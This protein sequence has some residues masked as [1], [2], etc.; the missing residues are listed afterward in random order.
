MYVI[1]FY[2]QGDRW[3][4]R[5]F[6]YDDPDYRNRQQPFLDKVGNVTASLPAKYINNLYKGVKRFATRP[7][8]FV[9]FTNEKLKVLSGIEVRPFKV[10][11]QMGVLPRLYMFSKEAGLFEHQVLCLDIDVVIVGSLKRIMNYKGLFC[12]RSK[13]K[14]GEGHK[15]DGD[16]MSFRAGEETE[17]IF[18]K[19]FIEDVEAAERLTGGRERYWFRHLVNDSADRWERYA[20]DQVIS[21][22]RHVAMQR[23]KFTEGM[24]VSIKRDI[25]NERVRVMAL[26]RRSNSP[27][28][29][30]ARIVSCHGT[31]RP[32]QIQKP[33]IK[34]YW[35]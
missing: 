8:E 12:A 17:D 24:P 23:K 5:G 1:C 33:W 15:L 26:K 20:P 2:W 10:V 18:W 30:N 7:F 25:V 29:T 35:K 32:D 9:C 22:K 34:E 13:F 28:P 6:K 19:P 31:P 21:Y 11:T 3:Q 4:Q 16:I 14:P 27:L